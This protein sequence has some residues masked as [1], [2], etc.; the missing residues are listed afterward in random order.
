MTKDR[1]KKKKTKK[2]KVAKV[3]I[4][5]PT[6]EIAPETHK[7]EPVIKEPTLLPDTPAPKPIV[8]PNEPKMVGEDEGFKRPSIAT[9]IPAYTAKQY[10]ALIE[11][12][13]KQNP[14]KYE[15]KR[16]ELE[17]KMRRLK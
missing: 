14:A 3:E 9:V 7:T 12:Y 10:K 2:E 15:K 6:V 17:A 16:S 5:Q 8:N 13:K 4:V 1:I 11:A